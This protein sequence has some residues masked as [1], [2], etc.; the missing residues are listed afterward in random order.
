MHRLLWLPA[1]CSAGGMSD[2][3]VIYGVTALL[4][5]A[6][7]I[8]C[9]LLNKKRN[10][11]LLLLFAGGEYRLLLAVRFPESEPGASCQSAGLSGLGVF[12]PFHVD[13][14]FAGDPDLLQKMDGAGVAGSGCGDV[15]DRR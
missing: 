10:P 12:A 6:L 5:L 2:L 4:S 15:S 13:V 14:H 1:V 7:L 9:C 3:S 8:G 11:W